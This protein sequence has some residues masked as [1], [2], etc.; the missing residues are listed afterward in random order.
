[1][2]MSLKATI[3][4][5]CSEFDLIPEVRKKK[6]HL[7]VS[8]IKEKKEKVNLIFICTHN[9]RRSHMAQIWAQIAAHHYGFSNVNCY[10]GGTETTAF[11]P[12]AIKTLEKQGLTIIKITETENPIYIAKY[13]N[14][15]P[16]IVS[17]SKEY[18]HSFNPQKKF[19][20]IMTCNQADLSCPL[21]PNTE[22][23]I[24]IQ[25]SDPKS[26]D[27]TSKELKEYHDISAQI[28]REMFFVFS[29]I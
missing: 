24:S 12:S 4:K 18:N 27:E 15:S 19:A 20:V 23:R 7:L 2:K 21:I 5:A 8:F 29:R 13:D 16:P 11:F 6:L 25:Y 14:T 22:K 28:C 3:K 1:M 26:A 9:S 10:S 17:F